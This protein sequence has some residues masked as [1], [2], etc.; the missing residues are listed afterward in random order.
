M[1]I[2]AGKVVGGHVIVEGEPLR[3]GTEVT[4]LVADE[5]TFTV[6]DEEKAFLLKSIAQADRGELL[7]ADDVLGQLP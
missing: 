2:A 5:P 4:V 1:R 6:T 7:N 3:D